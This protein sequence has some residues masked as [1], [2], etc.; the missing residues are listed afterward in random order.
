MTDNRPV[1]LTGAAGAL[2]RWLRPKLLA[3]YGRLRSADLVHP[4]DAAEGEECRV[5]D[6]AQMDAVERMVRGT[7][8]IVH[9]GAISVEDSWEN[10]LPANIVGTY[11]VFEAARREGVPRIV[12]ASSNH[13]I[14]YHTI[15]ERLD[16]DATIRPDTRY[17]VSKAYGEALGSYYHDKFGLEVACLRIGSAVPKPTL[18]RHLSTWL[19]YPDLMRL[20][21]AC[22]DAPTLGFA[23]VYGASNNRRCWW[24]NS[25]TP[26]IDYRP[27]DDA[28]AYAD[29]ILKNG[30]P[31]GNDD[32]DR[33]YMGGP[34]CA[35]TLPRRQG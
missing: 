2:G 11:N 28:E 23:I 10:I 34:F 32:P 3:R 4:G 27:E 7:R 8:A 18:P 5:V 22:L 9:L 33:I 20:V 16:A 30:D 24:D 35:D 6:I 25:K 26:E 21:G 19:S 31:R 29:E 15:D 13:A 1:L 17:G 14:G 12:F